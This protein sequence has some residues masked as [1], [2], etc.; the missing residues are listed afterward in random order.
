MPTS[1]SV[2]CRADFNKSLQVALFTVELFSIDAY[3]LFYL[4][5]NCFQ[6]MPTNC[7]V[8]CWA[9]F[10]KFLQ[11]VVYCCFQEMLTSC[12]IYCWSVFNKCLLVDLFTVSC[13]Q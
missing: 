2:Y 9:V 12:S 5:L 13:F 10:N 4:L 6:E 3:K 1:C 7:S 11:I 8:C